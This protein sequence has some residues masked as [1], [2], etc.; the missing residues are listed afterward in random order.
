[1]TVQVHIFRG[2]GR[3]F[4][5]A[6][7]SEGGNLPVKHGPW[8]AFKALELVRGHKQPGVNVEE[9]LDDIERLGLHV[10]DAHVR[11]TEQAIS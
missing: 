8:S 11:I 6:R 5:F 3:I 10:T 9:C 1:V 4:G 2:E 7:D